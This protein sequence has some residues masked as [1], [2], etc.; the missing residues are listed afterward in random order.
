MLRSIVIMFSLFSGVALPPIEVF[1]QSNAQHAPFQ[2]DNTQP[3]LESFRR[4]PGFGLPELAF[5]AISSVG[6]AYHHGGTSADAG[7]DCSGFVRA[8]YEQGLGVV[9]PR[10]AI[11]QARATLSIDAS[12]LEPGDLVFFNTLQEAFSH[13]GIYVGSGKFVHS[14]RSGMLV[15]LESMSNGYWQQRFDGARRVWRPQTERVTAGAAP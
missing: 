7:F 6:I 5:T 14:P 8:I 10:R 4:Q 3:A 12:E 13:V 11:D 9:L 1:A 15:R 2:S